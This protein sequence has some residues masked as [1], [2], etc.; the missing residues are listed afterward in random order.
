MTDT[1]FSGMNGDELDHIIEL[2]AAVFFMVIGIIGTVI[3]IRAMNE[4]VD[5]NVLQDKIEFK[6]TIT[7]ADY[8]YQ[9]TAWQAYMFIVV[10]NSQCDVS[11]SWVASPNDNDG[12]PTSTT[13]RY[14]ILDPV[15]HRQSFNTYKED[16]R[17]GTGVASGVGVAQTLA[18]VAKKVY[19]NDHTESN[20]Y[21]WRG[22][23]K[24]ADKPYRLYFGLGSNDVNG[25]YHKHILTTQRY[26]D[27]FKHEFDEEADRYRW[28]IS[29]IQELDLTH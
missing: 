16:L 25:V 29:P 9:Y 15:N 11:L 7:D 27:I 24:C 10:A 5:V 4:R 8:P 22:L 1:D 26:Y 14:V 17:K 2:I 12:S 20:V 21:N 13:N 23:D 6:S 3:M 18:T 19:G 28:I